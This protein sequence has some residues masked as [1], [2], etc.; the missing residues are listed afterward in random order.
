MSMEHYEEL[1]VL[2]KLKAAEIEAITS[3]LRLT[4]E[5]VMESVREK[6]RSGHKES[7]P[8]S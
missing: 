8:S 5:E 3:N 7:G 2:I 1:E 4:H 6:I